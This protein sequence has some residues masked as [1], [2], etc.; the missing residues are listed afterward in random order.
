MI[1]RPPRSTLFPYTTLFRSPPT[2]SIAWATC[3][4]SRSAS[5]RMTGWWPMLPADRNSTPLTSSH[6][7]P[8][9]PA[10]SSKPTA[11]SPMST[12]RAPLPRPIPASSAAP[13]PPA[14]LPRATAGLATGHAV[15]DVSI[16]GLSGTIH[17]ASFFFNDTA[18][19]EIY[20]LSLHDAL[21]ISPNAVN[22]V[23][24]LHTFTVSV[25]QDDGLVANAP[26]RSEFHTS[27]LQSHSAPVSRI[28]IETNSAIPDVNGPG[29]PPPANPSIVSGTT[30]AGLFTPRHGR[31]GHR[32][33]RHR[34]QHHRPERNHPPR[35]FFF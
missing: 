25:L 14:S 22:R 6:T 3:T 20:T 18:T 32:S 27:D 13:P 16:T 19:T 30:T 24:D 23:G 17:R 10:S 34:C 9:S 1:R 4:P 8:P 28:L 7:A 26:G 15:T 2:P 35:L 33:C 31:P 29:A 12:V 21:P 11:P 5:C